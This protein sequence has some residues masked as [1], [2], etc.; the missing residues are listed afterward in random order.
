MKVFRPPKLTLA[1][2]SLIFMLIIVSLEVPDPGDRLSSR[3]ESRKSY[4]LVE[5]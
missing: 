1:F 4:N 3:D 5:K 2:I